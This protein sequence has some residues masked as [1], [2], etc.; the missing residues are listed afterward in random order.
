MLPIP[1]ISAM[2]DAVAFRIAWIR[3]K[4]VLLLRSKL[5]VAF[6]NGVLLII[7]TPLNFCRAIWLKFEN[8]YSSKNYKKIADSLN[9][10]PWTKVD[11]DNKQSYDSLKLAKIYSSPDINS[12]G[13]ENIKQHQQEMITTLQQHYKTADI[14]K[15]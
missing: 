10:Q 13:I 3:S 12:W 9:V 4:F 8:K 6:W 1:G 2:S 11:F 7:W 14:E 15:E 5:P